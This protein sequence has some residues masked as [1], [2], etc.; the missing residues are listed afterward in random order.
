MTTINAT[1]PRN[2]IRELWRAAAVEPVT[3][4]RAGK[5]IAVVLSPDEYAR[6]VNQSHLRKG[7]FGRDILAGIN[8]DA[9]METP[10]DESFAGCVP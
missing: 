1:T 3:V 2:H 10:L 4:E 9:L 8:I 6:L 5:P 7:G